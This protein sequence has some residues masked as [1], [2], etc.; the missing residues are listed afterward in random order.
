MRSI[1]KEGVDVTGVTV[2]RKRCSCAFRLRGAGRQAE[3]R[4]MCTNMADGFD[5]SKNPASRRGHE[6][7]G[8]KVP[9]LLDFA[10]AE[11]PCDPHQAG[12]QQSQGAWLGRYRQV[13]IAIDDVANTLTKLIV[14][15]IEILC[16][17]AGR[18]VAVV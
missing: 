4:T 11:D 7:S 15:R 13:R 9:R 16:R 17:R 12:S 14:V 10:A 2:T 6:W 18:L 5:E 3:A 8:V 1:S